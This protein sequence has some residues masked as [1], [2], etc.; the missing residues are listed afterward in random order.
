[1][2]KV[3]VP[4]ILPL[5]C[6]GTKVNAVLEMPL[7]EESREITVEINSSHGFSVQVDMFFGRRISRKSKDL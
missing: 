1:M 5:E 2:Q 6:D 3:T 4:R 7:D